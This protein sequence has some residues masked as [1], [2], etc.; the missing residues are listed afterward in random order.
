RASLP[1]HETT[2]TSGS[3]IHIPRSPMQAKRNLRS[4]RT[5]AGVV[6]PAAAWRFQ[7]VSRGSGNL[8]AAQTQA[9]GDPENLRLQEP[10]GGPFL[11]SKDVFPSDP[12]QGEKIP[13]QF[14]H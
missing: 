10:A 6:R 11:R 3:A 14:P 5:G 1:S 9:I 13:M 2:P 8:E 4:N 12:A 7:P